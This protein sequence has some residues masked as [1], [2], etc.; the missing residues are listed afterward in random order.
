MGYYTY[1]EYR[2]HVFTEDGQ[3]M[4]LKIRDRA[5]Y[6]LSEAGAVRCDKLLAAAGG[7][8]NW[9]MLACIDRLVELGELRELS[10]PRCAGQD[11]VFVAG[12]SHSKG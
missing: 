7:G 11:R 1:S 4:F 12:Q 3:V 9:N 5:N 2:Q 8:L 10:N 6:L